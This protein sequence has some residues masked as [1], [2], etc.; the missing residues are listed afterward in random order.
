MEVVAFLRNLVAHRVLLVLG[1]LLAIGAGLA[2][3]RGQTTH[4]GVA[5]ARM[6]LDTPDS[7]LLLPTPQGADSLGWRAALLASLM[8]SHPVR[9]RIAHDVGL[10]PDRLVVIEPRLITP[11]TPTA[12]APRAIEASTETTARHVLT[13]RYDPELPIVT[14]EAHAPDRGGAARLAGAA[15]RELRAEATPPSDTPGMQKVVVEAFGKPR[16]AEIAHRP[17]RML[18]VAAAVVLFGLWCAGLTLA[19]AAA[20]AWRRAARLRTA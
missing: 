15:I 6:V 20:G 4:T 3:A 10:R 7:Q 2:L 16:V 9:E 18:P 1:A 8:S 13:V 19:L 12:L 5:S 14:L 11:T 17:S